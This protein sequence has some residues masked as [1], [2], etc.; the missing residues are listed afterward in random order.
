[1]DDV[2][3][4]K[5]VVD[6]DLPLISIIIPLFNSETYIAEAIKSVLG[7]T[8]QNWE[9]IIV[10][11]G[12]TD[13]S[14]EMVQPFL[15]DERVRLYSKPNGGAAS[16]RNLG[17]KKSNG[18]LIAFLDADDFWLPEKLENQIT[19]FRQYPEIGVCGTGMK[20]IDPQG[21]VL[22]QGTVPDFHGNPFP[23]ILEYSLANMT[24]AM[25]RRNVF[26]KSGLFD[27][28]LG[29][30]PEDYEFWLRVGKYTIFHVMS[31][32][33]ACYRCGHGNTSEVYSELRRELAIRQILPKFL[34][35][36]DGY[37]YVKWHQVRRMIAGSYKY[38]G[39]NSTKWRIRAWWYGRSI[40][41][42]PFYSPTWSAIP[43][44]FLPKSW[45]MCMKRLF[46]K[47]TIS[48]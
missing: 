5:S 26:E 18:N 41:V 25:I 1:M 48:D 30:A 32:P 19:C 2:T 6:T 33:L 43:G 38:R 13:R 8:W 11:D 34:H 47:T 42:W 29:K 17:I 9:L 10:D 37:K 4:Q 14:S 46:G 24:T 27:E 31:E 40:L 28:T 20:I 23:T 44:L 45:I 7:Q 21:Q 36:Q 22:S 35:E 12:S 39:D 3:L 15:K 16:A